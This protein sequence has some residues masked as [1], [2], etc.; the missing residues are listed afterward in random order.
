MVVLGCANCLSQFIVSLNGSKEITWDHLG[1]LVN[2]LVEGMLSIGSWFTPDDRTRL[3]T[4]LISVLCDILSVGFHIALLKVR[5]KTVHVLIVR[6]DCNRFGTVKVVVPG[7]NK[8]EGHGQVILCW[9]IKE[10]L[11]HG[12]CT[13]VHLHPVVESNTKSNWSSNGGPKGV[14]SSNPVPESKH[15]FC[16]NSELAN[17][18]SVGTERCKV[19]GD[20]GSIIVEVIEHPLFGTSGVGHSLLSGEGFTCYKEKRCFRVTLFQDFGHVGSIDVGAKMHG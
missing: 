7:T 3:N 14:S 5:G 15:I 13:S 6:K 10:V 20:G 18:R 8:G 16:I 11:I 12:V 9:S 19:L 2:E 1:T 4:N 17:T